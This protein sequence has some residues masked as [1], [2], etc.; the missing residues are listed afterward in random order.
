MTSMSPAVSLASTSCGTGAWS[1]CAL[2]GAGMIVTSSSPAA[3]V[4]SA[5]VAT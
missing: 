4:P 2:D 5:S 1:G 3:V